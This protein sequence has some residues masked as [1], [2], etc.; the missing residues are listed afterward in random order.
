[1]IVGIDLG[2]TNSLVA[3]LSPEGP[4]LIPNALGEVMTPS[5]VGLDHDGRLL[6]GRA[7][8]ELQVVAPERCASVFKRMMGTDDQ[9]TIADRE[10]RAEELSSM[11][12]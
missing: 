3:W 2:T 9:I 12:I 7:A 5:A 6:V 11:V 4:Q 10:F 1:M 8:K